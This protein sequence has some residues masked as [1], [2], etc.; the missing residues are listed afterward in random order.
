MQQQ[1]TYREQSNVFLIQADQ[2]LAR[3][4]LYQA[5]EKGWGAAAQI[6]KA[7]A[8]ERG[9]PHISHRHLQHTVNGLAQETQDTRLL[10]WYSQAESLHR[11]F[12][13]G[14]L[15][16]AMVQEYLAQVHLFVRR[17]ESLI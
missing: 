6:I 5:S 1:A 13:E 2:E 11:N 3:G 16:N 17:M 8:E 15:P 7:A 10:H 9:W 12:Y 4:D 14:T